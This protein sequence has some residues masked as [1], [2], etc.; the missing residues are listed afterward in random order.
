MRDR[1]DATLA[2]SSAGPGYLHER[3][4]CLQI[5][6]DV[7]LPPPPPPPLAYLLLPWQGWCGFVDLF[8][9]ENTP[10]TYTA[11]LPSSGEHHGPLEPQTTH[12]Y[13]YTYTHHHTVRAASDSTGCSHPSI[14]AT[15]T[16]TAI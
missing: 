13:T 1:L 6:L 7:P 11:R 16:T 9:L 8:L 5:V 4:L 10:S 3:D 12:T 14:T 15:A 2:H